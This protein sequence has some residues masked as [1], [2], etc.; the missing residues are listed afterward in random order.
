MNCRN[1]SNTPRRTLW[2]MSAAL[3]A[4]SLLLAVPSFGQ[5]GG[6]TCATAPLI[7]LPFTLASGTTCGGVDDYTSANTGSCSSNNYKAGEDI[8]WRFVAPSTGNVTITFTDNSGGAWMAAHLFLNCPSPSGT[9]IGTTGCSGCGAHS[10]TY[11]VTSGNT[12]YVMMDNWP[13]PSCGTF[14]NLSITIAGAPPSPCAAP[15][16]L[17]P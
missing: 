15:T 10:G 5:A 17:A 4:A 14:A 13:S 6:T 8:L 1:S 16:P 11:P 2:W 3:A 12:Y 7:T 9:C